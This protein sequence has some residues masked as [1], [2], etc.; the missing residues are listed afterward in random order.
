M[1]SRRPAAETGTGCKLAA[2]RGRAK[3]QAVGRDA[4]GAPSSVEHMG[5]DHGR[6]D[7]GMPPEILYRLDVVAIL[8]QVGGEQVAERVA[9]GRIGRAPPASGIL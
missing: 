6:A 8:E 5:V 1:L 3:R 9:G 7:V 4:D 2:G